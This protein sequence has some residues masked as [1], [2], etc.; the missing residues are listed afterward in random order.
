MNIEKNLITI[1]KDI[2]ELFL[3]H[4]NIANQTSFKDKDIE[5][6]LHLDRF[7]IDIIGKKD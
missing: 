5:L 4:P 1:D 7:S 3:P 6:S 2:E